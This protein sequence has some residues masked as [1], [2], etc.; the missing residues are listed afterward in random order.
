FE[1]QR[2]VSRP[3]VVPSRVEYEGGVS[4]REHG[5][6][7]EHLRDCPVRP[8]EPQRSGRH[9][10]DHC[11]ERHEEE[12]NRN[13]T[14]PLWVHVRRENRGEKSTHRERWAAQNAPPERLEEPESEW[15]H[16]RR[17]RR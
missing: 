7:A 14:I 13:L 9:E 5:D 11:S 2:E 3:R 6:Q 4:D 1:G 16:W 10:A 12:F 15:V 8:G 17:G